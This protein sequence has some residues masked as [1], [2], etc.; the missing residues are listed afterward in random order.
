MIKDPMS[1]DEVR[2]LPVLIDIPTAARAMSIGRSQ[3]FGLAKS[4]EFPIPVLRIGA[5]SLRIRSSDLRTYLGMD[6]S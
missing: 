3:A 1:A 5:R 4:G 6:A 2:A